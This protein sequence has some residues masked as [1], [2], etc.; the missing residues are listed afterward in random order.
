MSRIVLPRQIEVDLAVY[1]GLRQAAAFSGVPPK[2]FADHLQFFPRS[3]LAEYARYQILSAWRDK[4][5]GVFG[6]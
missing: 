6:P 4:H 3:D 1:A 2:L 5:P